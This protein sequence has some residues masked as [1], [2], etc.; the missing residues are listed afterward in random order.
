[1]LPGGTPKSSNDRI[2]RQTD[3]NV[4]RYSRAS[5]AAIDERLRELQREWPIERTLQAN[6]GALAL[7][8]MGLGAVLDR[9]YYLLPA[10]AVGLLMQQALHGW[11]PLVPLLRRLG[12]RTQIEIEQERYALKALRGDFGDSTRA[13]SGSSPDR[14]GRILEAIR[15]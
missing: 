10:L 6:A 13:M 8:G 12:Y 11:C 9:R 3:M 7:A 14:L 2:R 5:A 4:A 15:R 1:M